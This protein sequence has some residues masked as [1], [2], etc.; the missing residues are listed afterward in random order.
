MLP[1]WRPV[2]SPSLSLSPPPHPRAGSTS[3]RLS[4]DC[5]IWN[6]S[7]GPDAGA[8]P[9]RASSTGGHSLR[10]LMSA[11]LATPYPKQR[12]L[13]RPRSLAKPRRLAH[14]IRDKIAPMA[15]WVSWLYTVRLATR[16]LNVSSG[17]AQ[18]ARICKCTLTRARAHSMVIGL[19]F[20]ESLPVADSESWWSLRRGAVRVAR[21]L[22]L[23]PLMSS[24]YC[25]WRRNLSPARSSDSAS[26]R[27]RSQSGREVQVQV[28]NL[29]KLLC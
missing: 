14:S 15:R 6:T 2:F 5:T 25:H 1:L 17:R 3:C 10:R 22:I 20:C 23:V 21:T 8:D 27:A 18:N 26:K 12:R 11:Q 16:P 4:S 9:P 13:S 28:G 24:S 29:E 7:A 19:A